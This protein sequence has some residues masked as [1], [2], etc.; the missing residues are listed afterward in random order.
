MQISNEREREI[1]K[2]E[3]EMEKKIGLLFPNWSACKYRGG[4]CPPEVQR[5]REDSLIK[6]YC[7]NNP[8]IESCEMYKLLEN[9]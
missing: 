7:S 3:F 5:E 1:Q 6:K 4:C 8:S 2:N 9:R